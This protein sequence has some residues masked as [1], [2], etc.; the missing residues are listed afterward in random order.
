MLVLALFFGM[1]AEIRFGWRVALGFVCGCGI[2]YLN[3]HWLERVVTALADK[4][5]QTGKA[6]SSKGV[7]WRFLLRY[8]LM[9]LGGYAILTVLPR[10]CTAFWRAYFCP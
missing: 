2:A 1:A 10:S 7:V 4:I 6:P 9:G 8:I 3:L 5:T